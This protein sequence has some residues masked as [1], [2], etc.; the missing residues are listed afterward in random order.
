MV[1][2]TFND[3]VGARVAQTTRIGH[4]DGDGGCGIVV[5]VGAHLITD[6]VSRRSLRQYPIVR[7]SPLHPEERG[8]EQEEQRD[9]PP[10]RRAGRVRMTVLAHR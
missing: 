1:T 8:A 5:E 4:H 3:G 9:E 7:E 6:L 2:D 10:T